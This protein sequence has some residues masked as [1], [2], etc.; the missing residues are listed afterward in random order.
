MFS[1]IQRTLLSMVF[2][3]VPVL[4]LAPAARA[5]PVTYD[6]TMTA[7]HLGTSFGGIAALPAGPFTGSF[8]FEGP[9]GPDFPLTDIDLTAFTA[10]IGTRSWGFDDVVLSDFATDELGDI[11]FIEI[12][13]I[14]AGDVELHL[15]YFPSAALAMWHA[16]EGTCTFGPLPD[17]FLTGNCVAGDPNKVSLSLVEVPEPAT[18]ALLATGLA[19]LTWAARRRRSAPGAVGS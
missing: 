16:R 15:N 17:D 13:A 1:R 14:A 9:L 8:T 5:V 12:V 18:L 2:V 11:G 6:F 10:T 3:L 4:A 7:F 19:G